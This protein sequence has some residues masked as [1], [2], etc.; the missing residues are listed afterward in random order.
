MPPG[1]CGLPG[2]PVSIEMTP[3]NRIS[4]AESS[5]P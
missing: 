2:A 3:C 1:Y 5:I 4:T